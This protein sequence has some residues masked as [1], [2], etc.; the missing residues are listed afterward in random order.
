MDKKRNKYS[1]KELIHKAR[2]L[3]DTLKSL[4]AE[5]KSAKLIEQCVVYSIITEQ[6]RRY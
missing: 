2:I 1:N 3:K 6:L 4:Y 5:Q